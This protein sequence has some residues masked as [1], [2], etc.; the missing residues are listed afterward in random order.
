MSSFQQER[1]A[2]Q[3]KNILRAAANALYKKGYHGATMEEIA[4]EIRMTKG[5]IYYYF[6]NKEDLFYQCHKMILDTSIEKI[7][8]IIDRD[9][10]P[11]EKF[12]L[13][14]KSHILLAIEEKSMFTII[15]KPAQTFSSTE[16]LN[17]SL[18]QRKRYTQ[19]F[20]RIILE[21]IEQKYFAPLDYKI[22]RFII[23]GAM[24]WIQQWFS[25]DGEKTEEEIAD[26]FVEYF[27]RMVKPDDQA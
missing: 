17:D 4:N 7:Q 9:I 18:N 13:A 25:P 24:N 11:L 23:L 20:D 26:L 15:D 10:S 19:L 22:I 8:S 21:C 5:S 27:L 1:N 14:I 12:K 2:Q 3:R 6:K 16:N